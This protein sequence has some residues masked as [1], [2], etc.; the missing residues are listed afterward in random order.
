MSWNGV[1]AVDDALDA[2]RAFLFPATFGRWAR[3]AVVTLFGRGGGGASRVASNGANLAAQA[4]NGSV[5]TGAGGTAAVAVVIAALATLVDGSLLSIATPTGPL[6]VGDVPD[7]SSTLAIAAAA[8][9]LLIILLFAIISSVFEFVLVDAIARDSIRLVRDTRRHLLNGFRFLGFQ[10]G[11]TAAFVVPLAAVTAALVLSE[12][13][14]MAILDRP[15][16]VVAAVLAILVYVLVFAFISR[17]TR[18]FVVPAMVADGSGV[19]DGWRRVWPLLRGNLG[20]T[21]VYLVMHL[22][23][24]I[25]IGI[26][27]AVLTLVGLVAVGTVAGIVGLVVGAVVGGTGGDLGVGAGALAAVIVGVPLLVVAVFLPI[28][29][30]T[31]TYLRAYELAALGRFSERLDLLGRYRDLGVER[32]AD[33]DERDDGISGLSGDDDG[34]DGGDGDGTP[35]ARLD[36]SGESADDDTTSDATDDFGGFVPASVSDDD[37]ADEDNRDDD[38]TS[39]DPGR[40]N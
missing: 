25:G 39:D 23:V 10:I 14:P 40:R 29:V 28:R 34:D 13:S 11:L 16:V 6:Q 30:L 36:D 32:A 37:E 38:D 9:V 26:V 22:L 19:I 2:T 8:A 31:T 3:L 1:D 33:S 20:Q 15:L 27:G 18:E 17:F 21:L 24:G 12:T 5:P 7:V 35:D 4:G